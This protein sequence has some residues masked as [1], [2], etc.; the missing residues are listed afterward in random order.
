MNL[1][2][3]SNRSHSTTHP[4]ICQDRLERRQKTRKQGQHHRP[5]MIDLH[6]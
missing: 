6:F 3:N 2:Y 1:S 4:P 5:P